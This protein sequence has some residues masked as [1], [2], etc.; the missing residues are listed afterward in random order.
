MF[1]FPLG[2]YTFKRQ[3]LSC[4]P[5]K[6]ALAASLSLLQSSG[7]WKRR[8]VLPNPGDLGFKYDN[9]TGFMIEK[10][11][12]LGE[13][14]DLWSN[15]MVNSETLDLSKP[16]NFSHQKSLRLHTLYLTVKS[17]HDPAMRIRFKRNK[18]H[19]CDFQCVR[20]IHKNVGIYCVYYDST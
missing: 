2:C 15:S 20:N 8:Q 5:S 9:F 17:S 3:Q 14:L 11:Q 13:T 4:S 12:K 7:R 6:A 18:H 16:L 19:G 1:F 10:W